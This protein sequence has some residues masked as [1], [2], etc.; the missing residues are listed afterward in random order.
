MNMIHR[1]SVKRNAVSLFLASLFLISVMFQGANQPSSLFNESSNTTTLNSPPSANLDYEQSITGAGNN[2]SVR[3][4]MDNSSSTTGINNFNISSDNAGNYLNEGQYNLTISKNYN[5]NYTLEDDTPLEYPTTTYAAS[6]QNSN[7]TMDTDYNRNE[8]ANNVIL[9]TNATFDGAAYSNNILGFWIELDFVCTEGFTLSISMYNYE[10]SLYQVL[11]TYSANEAKYYVRNENLHYL[12]SSSA[13]QFSLIFYNGTDD[14]N[15]NVQSIAITAVKAQETQISDENSVA[16]EFDTKGDATI[17]GFY[18]WIRSFNVT[19]GSYAGNLTIK[20]YESNLTTARKR[21]D[22]ILNA[23]TSLIVPDMTVSPLMEYTIENYTSDKPAWFSFENDVLGEEVGVGNYYIVISSNVSKDLT[24]GYSLV[25]IPDSSDPDGISDHLLLQ[26]ETSSWQQIPNSDAALFAVNLTRA[27]FPEEIELKIENEPVSNAYTFDDNNLYDSFSDAFPYDIYAAYWW[28]CGTIDHVYN[29]PIATVGNKMQVNLTWNTEIYSGDIAFTVSYD[30]QKY[31]DD[32]ATTVYNLTLDESP[33]WNVNYIYNST[34][35]RF[36]NWNLMEAWYFIPLDWDVADFVVNSTTTSYLENITFPSTVDDQQVV[37]VQELFISASGTYELQATSNN[38]IQNCGV[39][40][41]YEGN[42]WPTNGFMIGDNV[43][44]TVGILDSEDKYLSD[45]IVTASL[46][47]TTGELD[48]SYILTDNSIDENTTYSRYLFE[49]D[50]AILSNATVEGEYNIIV[51]WTNGEEAGILRRPF[52][53]NHYAV[54]N[55]IEI[56]YQSD[57]SA[58]QITAG[59]DTFDTDIHNNEYNI[60]MYAVRENGGENQIDEETNVQ[61]LYNVY[62]TNYLQ[63]ET[64]FNA[65]EDVNIIIDLENRHASLNLNVDVKVQLVYQ[66]NA[67]MVIVE[68]SIPKSL[69]IY[70]AS[71]GLD[72]QKY[73]FTLSIPT[74]QEGGVNCPI[75]N[76]PMKMNIIATID[77]DEIYSGMQDNVIYYS[78]L[79]ETSFDGEILDVKEYNARSGPSFI[80]NMPRTNLNLPETVSYFIQ[81][82][83]GYLMTSDAEICDIATEITKVD[84]KIT[85]L[86][87]T[88]SE[89]DH[90][91]T[92]HLVGKALDE[93]GNRLAGTS[94]NLFYD[95]TPSNDTDDWKALTT[96]ADLTTITTNANGEFTA[97]IDLSQA[98]IDT[99]LELKVEFPGNGTHEEMSL[100]LKESMPEYESILSVSVDSSITMIAD[101]NNVITVR[102]MNNGNTKLRNITVAIVESE[103]EETEI[104]LSDT[105][106]LLV[107]NPYEE[108]SFQIVLNQKSFD[109]NSISL[110]FTVK[111]EIEQTGETLEETKDVEFKTYAVNE[112]RVLITATVIAFI[113]GTALFWI[114]GVIYI[115][116]KVAEINAPVETISDVKKTKSKRRVGKY[117]PISE[118]STK[119]D[120]VEKAKEESSTSLDDLLDEE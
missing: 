74:V 32:E 85:D 31:F 50:N 11:E 89:F 13:A 9:N 48:S 90:S 114:Y 104:L 21:S 105:F 41:D 110:N 115:K 71:S 46:F 28:G 95:N 78:A 8:P 77:G 82:E 36:V 96:T 98:P 7:Y 2:R 94:L 93:Y 35:D 53:V 75:R 120:E 40:L 116:K 24:R 17:Y 100:T 58:N 39:N 37:K 15:V 47:N 109:E 97:I 113:A 80:G 69:A 4:F 6:T 18:A 57:I 22:I 42:L 10:T 106:D 108:A 60:F 49:S 66:N 73:N 1:N 25:S 70:G 61:M 33:A 20:L 111:C 81:L 112:N 101:T 118:L 87:I 34:N 26:N 76:S 92:V 62:M 52:Y 59:I 107:L 3:L 86:Y 45:G 38:Y 16:L 83:N 68:D 30:V 84:G 72:K 43:S 5:T 88:E 12:N 56:S 54:P 102:L 23:G 64:F 119:S 27:Y 63:N 79:N 29:T 44:I 65:G 67:E 117:V 99:N 51:N 14:F 103:F 19:D 55:P 91:S